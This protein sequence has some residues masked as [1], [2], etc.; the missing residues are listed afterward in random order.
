MKRFDVLVVGAGAAGLAAARELRSRGCT[1]AVLEGRDR[2]GGRIDTRRLPGLAAPVELGAEFVHGRPKLTVALLREAGV[3]TVETAQTQIAGTA[4]E[5]TRTDDDRFAA[6]ADLFTRVDLEA[7]DES[8]DAFLER[9]ASAPPMQWLRDYARA[10]VEGFDAADPAIVSVRSLALEWNGAASIEEGSLRPATGYDALVAHL[11]RSLDDERATLVRGAVVE[12]IE[13]H[14]GVTIDA[15]I[16]GELHRFEGSRAIVTV[17]IGV[18]HANAIAF[19]PPL[20]QRTAQA[21]DAIAMGGVVKIALQFD[22]RFWDDRFGDVAFFQSFDTPFPAVWTP[23]PQRVPLLIAWAGGTRTQPLQPLDAEQRVT[24][25]LESIASIFG[26]PVDAVR[27]HMVASLE[28]D[29]QKDPFA[30]G[31]YS[32]ERVGAGDARS[33]LA[34]PVGPL[35]FAGEATAETAQAGTVTGALM[36]GIRAANAAC[37]ALAHGR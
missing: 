13:R 25:A 22:E 34:E 27:A 21:I 35:H 26:M 1:V 24:R 8:L 10:M 28:H 16:G 19:D 5:A 23:L 31:A 20:P 36:S 3:E 29:W 12:R 4:G 11:A 30:R 9:E 6:V 14:D 2:L 15:R 33:R 7:P 32:Y 18:L 17:P 37:G